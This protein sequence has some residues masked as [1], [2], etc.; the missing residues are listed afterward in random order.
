MKGFIFAVLMFLSF[1]TNA[2]LITVLGYTFEDVVLDDGSQMTGAFYWTYTAE[3]F[4]GGTGVFT[5]LVIPYSPSSTPPLDDPNMTTLIENN[6]IEI[7][8]NGS[9]HDYGLDIIM[10]FIQPLSPT[11]PS[12]INL[13]T[14]KYECCGNGFQTHLFFSGSIVPTAVPIPA[15]IWLFGSGLL[16]IVLV[17]RRSKA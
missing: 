3:D 17:G 4:E 11:Q 12:V 13:V 1:G 14:S 6:Q 15:A 5:S 9:L 10:K 7:S 16:G 8:G 2:A